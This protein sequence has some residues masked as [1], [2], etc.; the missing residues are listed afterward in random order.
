MKKALTLLATIAFGAVC[1][2]AY[3][4]YGVTDM[5]AWPRNWPS[6]LEPLRQQARTFE[7]PVAPDRHYAMRFTTRDEFEAAW[8]HLLKIKRARLVLV[9]GPNFFLGDHVKAGVVIHT[10]PLGAGDAPLPGGGN[11]QTR[12]I[13]TT[14]LEVI[15]DGEIIDLNRIPL[16]SDGSIV[17][18]RFKE[19]KNK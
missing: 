10:P 14:Y 4:D 8:P 11:V 2:T 3:S 1:A 7:G 17:D 15:V 18:D 13:S 16:P 5:G 6:E 19:R 12:G 9:R